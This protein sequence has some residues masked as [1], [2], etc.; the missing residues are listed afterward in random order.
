MASFTYH[1][2]STTPPRVKLRAE[3]LISLAEALEHLEGVK[4]DAALHVLNAAQTRSNLVYG[5]PVRIKD[6]P[7]EYRLL[8]ELFVYDKSLV[9]HVTPR[10]AEVLIYLHQTGELPL[11]EGAVA[12]KVSTALRNYTTK[13]PELMSQNKPT[14]AQFAHS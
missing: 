4:T 1:R 2:T 3:Q 8:Q 12:G 5:K 6:K 14:Y 11:E 7:V 9:P 13:G 10:G